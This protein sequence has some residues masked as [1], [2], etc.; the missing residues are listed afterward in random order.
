MEK[1][2]T[3]FVEA[4]KSTSYGKESIHCETIRS[5]LKIPDLPSVY[6]TGYVS[7]V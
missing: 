4:V 5:L 1:S 6:E 3:I 7:N 2:T